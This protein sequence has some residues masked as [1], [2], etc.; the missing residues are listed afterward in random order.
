M[1]VEAVLAEGRNDAALRALYE[2]ARLPNR[3]IA[4]ATAEV[5]QRLLG[6]DL[7]IVPGEPLPPLN[8]ID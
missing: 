6:V 4:L 7:G 3:E 8:R 2:I 1:A 5:A